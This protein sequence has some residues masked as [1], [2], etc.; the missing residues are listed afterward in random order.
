MMRVRGGIGAV[1]SALTGESPDVDIKAA[2]EGAS[3]QERSV[4][5]IKAGE[6]R[7]DEARES[8]PFRAGGSSIWADAGCFISIR[9]PDASSAERSGDAG[10]E[11]S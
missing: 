8:R 11:A 4:F 6:Q 2:Y 5:L 1:A 9:E 10:S 7:K 3:A